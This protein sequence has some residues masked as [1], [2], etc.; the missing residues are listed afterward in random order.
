MVTIKDVA[1]RAGVNASTVSRALKDSQS[2]SKKTKERVRQAMEELGYVPNVAAKMLASG[3]T[4]CVGVILPPLVSPDRVSEPFFMEILTAI[5]DEA[6]KHDFT[7]SMAVSESMEDL[8]RQVQ[9]LYRQRRVDGFIVLYSETD[10]PVRR[11]LAENQIPFVIVGSPT[12]SGSETVYIDNDN[13]L[14]A[15]TAVEYLHDK[16]HDQIL[17]VTDDL[18]SEIFLERYLG[19]LKGVSKLKLA[20][21]EAQL[22][23]REQAETLHALIEKIQSESISALIVIGDTLSIRVIQLLSFYGIKVPDDLSLLSFNNSIYSTMLHPYLTTFDINVEHLGRN[24][25][26]YLVKKINHEDFLV[27]SVTVPFHLQE[28][29]SVTKLIRD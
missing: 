17:F 28:R 22:F 16:G 19:Y 18:E 23:D 1:E 15:R 14:M 3:L 12:D 7:I 29:E 21:F 24:S 8:E 2:I 20:Q 26:S 4:Y 5:A 27:S 9:L 10:D 11:F 13:Q 25:V 6:K